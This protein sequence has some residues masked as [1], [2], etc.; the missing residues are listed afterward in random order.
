ML[1]VNGTTQY[2]QV[3]AGVIINGNDEVLVARRADD[4]HQGGLWEFPGGKLHPG[5]S[6]LEAL[7]RELKEELGIIIQRQ[8]PFKRIYHHYPDKSVCL[9]VWCV[10]EWD[11]AP[12]GREGQAINWVPITQTIHSTESEQTAQSKQTAQSE[13]T[14]RSSQTIR[15]TGLRPEDFP[16]A[17]KSILRA[18]QLPRYIAITPEL[19]NQKA[20]NDLL[21]HY[22]NNGILA[23]Q[24][25]QHQLPA[26][27]YARWF[28]SALPRCE[29]AGVALLVNQPLSVL[30]RMQP[31]C[32]HLNSQTLMEL[33]SRPDFGHTLLTASCHN[34]TELEK[35]EQIDVDLALLSPVQ[36][37]G[38]ATAA[39]ATA[40]TKHVKNPA[41][42]WQ[43]FETLAA[44][45]SLPVYALGGTAPADWPKVR[46]HGGMGVAGITAFQNIYNR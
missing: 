11:G 31:A 23:V 26:T 45:A 42:G 6:V 14:A 5:E 15:T 44:M 27:E 46:Q 17:N 32:C 36:A 35:A 43:K 8:F 21:T 19:P 28:Q 38:I 9:N 4:A 18:L 39:T 24:L 34:Q 7:R 13:Q 1:N 2:T 3:A 25:R 22:I 30:T 33:T 37:T 10:I 12:E 16:V 20:L 41:L 29:E 40:T